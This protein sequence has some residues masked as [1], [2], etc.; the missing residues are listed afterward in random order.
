MDSWA[1]ALLSRLDHPR[2]LNHGFLSNGMSSK[3]PMIGLG[4]GP[5]GYGA[6]G[7]L[8]CKNIAYEI[9][10]TRG[11]TTS[12]NKVCIVSCMDAK[13]IRRGR[14]GANGVPFAPLFAFI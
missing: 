2:Y 6:M 5:G 7:F 9:R 11:G 10:Q 13:T 14:R 4:G 12:V 1:N 3:L 8:I